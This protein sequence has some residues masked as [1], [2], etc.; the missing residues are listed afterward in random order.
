MLLLP[1]QKVDLLQQLFLVEL[2]GAHAA[3]LEVSNSKAFCV[4]AQSVGL[5]WSSSTV[6]R[7]SSEPPAPAL[8]EETVARRAVAVPRRDGTV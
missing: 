4:S 1:L 6:D 7:Q 5:L 3:A 8:T 2:E